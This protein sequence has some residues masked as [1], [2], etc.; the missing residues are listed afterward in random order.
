[1]KIFFWLFHFPPWPSVFT[2]F[3]SAVK[4]IRQKMMMNRTQK[5]SKRPPMTYLDQKRGDGR[6]GGG[7]VSSRFSDI[8]NSVIY[9]LKRS[10]D[11]R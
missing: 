3:I 5:T 6:W 2:F 8:L 7:A 9:D 4:M 11:L 1:M 10:V